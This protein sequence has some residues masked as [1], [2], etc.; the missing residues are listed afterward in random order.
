MEPLDWNVLRSQCA[1]DE[2]LVREL[3]ELYRKEW[4]AL[5]H[6]VQQAVAAVDL[7]AARRTAHRLKGA[8]LSLAAI[9]S[10]D[11]AQALERAAAAADVPAMQAALASLELELARLATALS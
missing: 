4:G 1:G 10:A 5:L 8:L 7:P 9:P 6:D 11:L 3:V 2:A